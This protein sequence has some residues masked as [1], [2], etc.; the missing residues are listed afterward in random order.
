MRAAMTAGVVGVLAAL[1]GAASAGTPFPVKMKCP[2]GGE[3]FT[4]VDT[5]SYSTWG[6]RPDGKPYG[7]WEFPKPIP[8][9]PGNRLVVFAEFSQAQVKALEPLLASAEYRSLTGETSYYRALWLAKALNLPD[10]PAAWLLLQASWQADGDVERKARY[11][12][13][14]V[15]AIDAEPVKGADL[16]W[17]SMQARAVN[18]ERELGA[19]DAATARIQR[20]RDQLKTPPADVAAEGQAGAN[21]RGGLVS[22]LKLQEGAIA[23]K[24]VSPEPI[25]LVSPRIGARKCIEMEDAGGAVSDLCKTVAMADMIKRERGIQQPIATPAK[26]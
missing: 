10:T 14:F 26:P 24:D 9:C 15:A 20:L 2:V 19:F 17:L 18:A 8:E 13:E 22:F 5:M 25:D 16:T 12:R 7:S 21:E 23:R 6:S 1:A 11:Q 3:S 4:Y